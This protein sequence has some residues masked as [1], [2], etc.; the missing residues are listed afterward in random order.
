MK[1]LLFAF[2]AVAVNSL[3]FFGCSSG[4][5][6]DP[7]VNPPNQTTD[8]AAT[9]KNA[10][11]ACYPTSDI[12]TKARTGVNGIAGNRI[13][14]YA[15][16]GYPAA[17]TNALVP[18]GTTKTVRLG[19][20]YDPDQKGIPGVI[21]SVPIKIIHLVVSAVWCNPCNQETDLVS[22][23]NFSGANP[24]G[25]SWAKELA[26]LGVVFVQALDDGAVTGVGATLNDLNSWINHHGVNFT[27]VLD[28]NN[29]NLGVFFDAAA[30]PF[31]ANIDARSMEILSSEVGFDTNGD[32]AIKTWVNWVGSHPAKQ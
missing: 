25:T 24:N 23:A 19:D 26:P 4:A 14:N 13:A 28:P 9:D 12:G 10:Y 11:G 17:D 29:Q 18:D 3:L 27:D 20:Y 6:P 1:H 2:G 5:P 15:F 21:G 32:T 7:G 31:N 16:T 8:C 30:I 22:G